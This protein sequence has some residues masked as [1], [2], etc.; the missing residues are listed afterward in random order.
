MAVSYMKAIQEGDTIPKAF[1]WILC[2]VLWKTKHNSASKFM[3]SL[4][5]SWGSSDVWEQRVMMLASVPQLRVE[6][7]MWPI[8][9]GCA[10]DVAGTV[11]FPRAAPPEKVD[12]PDKHARA[13]SCRLQ[14]GGERQE[15]LSV[16]SSSD[17]LTTSTLK[18][19]GTGKEPQTGEG[20]GFLNSP[21]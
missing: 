6:G 5:K 10:A 15:R 21:V 14:A 3:A 13:A 2:H 19:S 11:T 9:C 12:S 1:P 16:W 17:G 18:G 8:P 4:G 20:P 7:K